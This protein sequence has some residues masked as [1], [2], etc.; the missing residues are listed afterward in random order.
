MVTEITGPVIEMTGVVGRLT[1]SKDH[2]RL[3][4]RT[5]CLC[6]DARDTRR[7]GARCPFLHPYNMEDLQVAIAEYLCFRRIKRHKIFV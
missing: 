6:R 4:N 2:S 7:F 5:T 3:L 1:N